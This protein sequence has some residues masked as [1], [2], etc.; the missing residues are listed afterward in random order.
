VFSLNDK[1][2]MNQGFGDGL[3]RAFEL[4]ATPA[5]FGALGYLIDRIAGTMP[6][7]T[8]VLGVFGLVGTFLRAWYGYDSEMRALESSGRWVRREHPVDDAPPADLW[9]ARKRSA[10]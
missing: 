9:S 6:V 4:V 2:A 1:R 5:V 8:V 10:S 3:A 7:F